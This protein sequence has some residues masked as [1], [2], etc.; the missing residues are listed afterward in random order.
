MFKTTKS[1]R[2]QF[3][4]LMLTR[5]LDFRLVGFSLGLDLGIGLG[6]GSGLGLPSVASVI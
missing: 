6:S 4:A 3:R 2:K 5:T 1:T